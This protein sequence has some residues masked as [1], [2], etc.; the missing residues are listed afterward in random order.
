MIIALNV[1]GIPRAPAVAPIAIAAIAS[2]AASD[3]RAGRCRGFSRAEPDRRAREREM[4]DVLD[5]RQLGDDEPV[6]NYPLETQNRAAVLYLRCPVCQGRFCELPDGR[7][8]PWLIASP[9]GS[10]EHTL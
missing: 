7:P 2:A 8:C 4:V 5:V 9:I 6:C 10:N 3:R 1:V